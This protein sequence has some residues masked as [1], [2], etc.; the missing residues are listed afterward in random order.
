MPDGDRGSHGKAPRSRLAKT[1]PSN[2]EPRRDKKAGDAKAHQG[3]GAHRPDG[4][5][6][7]V[8]D[9]PHPPPEGQ[10]GNGEGGQPPEDPEIGLARVIARWTKVMGVCAIVAVCVSAA[11]CVEMKGQ[12][13][14]MR[15]AESGSAAQLSAAERLAAAAEN[16]Y[17]AAKSSA[18]ATASLASVG[19]DQLTEMHDEQRPR[20]AVVNAVIASPLFFDKDGAHVTI[21]FSLKNNG[22]SDAIYAFPFAQFFVRN[23]HEVKATMER[24]QK[25]CSLIRRRTGAVAGYGTVIGPGETISEN[26]VLTMT[27]SEVQRWKAFGSNP[28]V[29]LIVT[30]M[31]AGCVDYVF[32]GGHHQTTFVYELDRRIPGNNPFGII[33]AKSG[34]TVQQGDL[35]LAVNPGLAAKSD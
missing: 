12:L 32:D 25:F 10:H 24:Q 30:A 1:A 35:V 31:V 9:P 13:K 20:V 3:G 19:R 27:P 16:E 34:Q 22:H 5:P 18:A 29:S 21:T 7:G 26:N 11:Q 33:D 17:S 23:W 8:N 28:D 6:P 15:D 14:E 4:G 2:G